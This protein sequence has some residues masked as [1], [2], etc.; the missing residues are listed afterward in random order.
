[1]GFFIRFVKPSLHHFRFPPLKFAKSKM[2][3]FF[4]KSDTERNFPV[5]FAMKK[6]P[7]HIMIS[8]CVDIE[9]WIPYQL[10]RN[11]FQLLVGARSI[12][13]LDKACAEALNSEG[14][15]GKETS[16]EEE[17]D[18]RTPRATEEDH[19]DVRCKTTHCFH[20][21]KKL[22][23]RKN[24]IFRNFGIRPY[25]WIWTPQWRNSQVG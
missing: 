7:K 6:N 21:A 9:R 17:M 15:A 3:N 25:H 2:C 12:G 14:G 5:H 10:S 19:A 24:S 1:M 22:R 23:F 8:E 11:R 20:E 4:G 13:W 18:K 16:K